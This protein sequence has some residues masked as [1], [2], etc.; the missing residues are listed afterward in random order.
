ME[1]YANDFEIVFLNI[2]PVTD[3]P[4]SHIEHFADTPV[5]CIIIMSFIELLLFVQCIF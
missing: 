3:K 4:D 1:I 2:E 5:I